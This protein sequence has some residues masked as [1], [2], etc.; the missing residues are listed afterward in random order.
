MALVLRQLLAMAGPDSELVNTKDKHNWAPLHILASGGSEPDARGGMI[1]QLCRARA[2][3]NM[4]KN[5]GATPLM[6]AAAT[7]QFVAVEALMENGA[8]PNAE[9]DEGTTALDQARNSRKRQ[10]VLQDTAAR[11]GAGTTGVGRLRTH[12]RICI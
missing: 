1:R 2:D 8:D 9:N 5:R 11:F 4:T 3:V 10:R 6:V 12:T 7:S